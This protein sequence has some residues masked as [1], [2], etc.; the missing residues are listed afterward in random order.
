[1]VPQAA[2]VEATATVTPGTPAPIVARGFPCAYGPKVSPSAQ[3]NRN[4]EG[5]P[6]DGETIAYAGTSRR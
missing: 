6:I 1:M 4:R 5:E 2:T 3:G